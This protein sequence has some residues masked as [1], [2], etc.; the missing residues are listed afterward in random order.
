MIT[1]Q[2]EL[3]LFSFLGMFFSTVMTL[4]WLKWFMKERNSGNINDANIYLTMAVIS[5]IIFFVATYGAIKRSR[6]IVL[7]VCGLCML[8]PA[9]FALLL[10][11]VL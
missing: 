4:M 2:K 5:Q 10:Q 1:S 9:C 8:I 3:K 7:L 6:T 11:Y